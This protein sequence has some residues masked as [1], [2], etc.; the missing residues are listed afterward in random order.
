LRAV[1]HGFISKNP[2][3]LVKKFKATGN[4]VER[5]NLTL[6]EIGQ[7]YSKA[8]NEFGDA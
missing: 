5:R 2:V 8:P 6:A 4:E 1:D 3:A 7:A